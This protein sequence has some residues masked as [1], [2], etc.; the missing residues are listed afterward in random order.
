ML[1]A[2][3]DLVFP[4]RCL[5]CGRRDQVLCPDCRSGI[6]PLSAAVCPRCARAERLGAVCRQCQRRP[7][8]LDALAAATAYEGVVRRAILDLKF[9]QRRYLAPLLAE[10][11]VDALRRRPLAADVLIPVPLARR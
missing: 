8:A 3:W 6:A 11:L 5:G 1:A 2:L 9:R 4:A 10:L 7:G